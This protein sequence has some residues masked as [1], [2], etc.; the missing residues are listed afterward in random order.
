MFGLSELRV[1]RVCVHVLNSLPLD[2]VQMWGV[3]AL[4][5]PCKITCG[6]QAWHLTSATARCTLGASGYI[7]KA[8]QPSP[9]FVLKIW[10]NGLREGEP[11][12]EAL[13]CI[14]EGRAF[15]VPSVA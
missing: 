1:R 4:T 14:R 12:N 5:V 11:E 10:K 8:L 15:S 13:P 7:K 2:G 3:L 6:L 9:S